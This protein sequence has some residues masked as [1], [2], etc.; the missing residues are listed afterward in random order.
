MLINLSSPVR[1]CFKFLFICMLCISG[2]A[3][4]AQ[5]MPPADST[6]V[7]SLDALLEAE[8]ARE[9]AEEPSGGVSSQT[10]A[11]LQTGGTVARAGAS[12]N[13]RISLIGT[14]L[15]AATQEDAVEKKLDLGLQET[16]LV[17]DAYIDP[18]AKATFR[19]GI[20]NERENPFEGP[21]AAVAFDGE[22]HTELEE[23][24]LTTLGLPFSLQLK[25]G[26]FLGTFGKINQTHPH[27]WNFI[28]QPLMYANYL[29]EEGL[30]DRGLSLSW[31]MP[32]PFGIYQELTV[33]ATSGIVENPSFAA[34]KDLLY[35]MHLKNFVDLNDNTTL[36]LGLSGIRGSNDIERHKSQI[37]AVD[38]TFRWKPLRRNRYKSFEWM[39]EALLSRRQTAG[40]TISS[41]AF[42]SFVRHQLTKRFFLAGR[43]DYSEFPEDDKIYQKA[44]S[45][46]LSFYATEFQ[47]IDLQY[48]YGSPADRDNFS[49]LLLRAV[50]VIGAHGAHKY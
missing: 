35:L 20:H 10:A 5:D 39:S 50:F 13:P 19:I 12:L 16:E 22:F 7:D 23:G 2:R 32:N 28:D 30:L 44:A 48:Q 41:K 34:N 18:Y 26:K 14:F 37:G 27:A 17:F 36:E 11:T 45:A 9:L 8:L 29:G 47:K 25:A 43:Y 31:L 33:E 6:T 46:I 24:Y 21:D 1:R 3:L 40:G 49:R 42:Y 15:G 4:N 38:L